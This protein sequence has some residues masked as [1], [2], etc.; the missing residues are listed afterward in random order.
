MCQQ[1]A[2][3]LVPL[4]RPFYSIRLTQS[5]VLPFSPSIIHAGS[6]NYRSLTDTTSPAAPPSSWRLPPHDSAGARCSS[7]QPPLPSDD[8][9]RKQDEKAAD[10]AKYEGSRSSDKRYDFWFLYN[11]RK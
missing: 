3:S 11:K 10:R 6:G 1:K 9:E 2:P 5:S 4:L 8:R 7:R